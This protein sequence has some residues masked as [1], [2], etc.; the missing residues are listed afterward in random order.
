[1]KNGVFKLMQRESE[2]G[3]VQHHSMFAFSTDILCESLF[4]S[5]KMHI[6]PLFSEFGYY[7]RRS[8]NSL[9]SCMVLFVY[10]ELF[11]NIDC[12]KNCSR[13]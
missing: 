7:T 3:E 2:R 8:L 6:T 5:T 10:Q 11:K 12:F 4:N 1:M 13:L 9:H